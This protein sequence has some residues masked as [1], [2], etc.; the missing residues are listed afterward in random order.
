[1]LKN[2]PE[3]FLTIILKM[4][5]ASLK[6]GRI[7]SDWKKSVVT[8]IPKGN[9]PANDPKN[10]RPISNKQYRIMPFEQYS[11]SDT[12]TMSALRRL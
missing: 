8:M 2:L 12:M 4:C 11:G 9:K 3:E 10:Y 1:M 7:A 6:E 5:N